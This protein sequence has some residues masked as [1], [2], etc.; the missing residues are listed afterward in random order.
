[1]RKQ[2]AKVVTTLFFL[3]S[4]FVTSGQNKLL[5]IQDQKVNTQKQIASLVL[6]PEI[7]QYGS[8]VGLKDATGKN[9]LEEIT[10]RWHEGYAIAYQVKN[11]KGVYKDR[12]V[13]VLGGQVSASRLK[14]ERRKSTTSRKVVTTRDK[15]L[16]IGRLITWDKKSRALKSDMTITNTSNH[17]VMLRAIEIDI[18]KRVAARLTLQG[19]ARPMYDL[20][21]PQCPTP[22]PGTVAIRASMN[23]QISDDCPGCPCVTPPYCQPNPWQARAFERDHMNPRLVSLEDLIGPKLPRFKAPMLCLSWAGSNLSRSVLKPGEQI[24]VHYRLIIP[25]PKAIVQ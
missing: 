6:I 5:D 8:L 17:E 20:P 3:T 24:L 25:Q 4:L 16:E 1:M 13:Y 19:D 22:T 2:V 15:A 10:R 7:S 12:F 18:D 14:V 23:C 11:S 21:G 9:L